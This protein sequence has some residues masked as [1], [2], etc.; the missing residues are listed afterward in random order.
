MYRASIA[1]RAQLGLL[2]HGSIA[3]Y[4]D[5]FHACAKVF[6]MFIADRLSRARGV[7]FW[8]WEDLDPET[9]DARC[10]SRHDTGVD[11]SDGVQCIVQ[12]KLRHRSLTWRECATFFAS[13]IAIRQDPAV[14]QWSEML[15]ARNACSTLSRDIAFLRATRKDMPVLLS[16]FRAYVAACAAQHVPAA[17]FP[18][19][20]LRDYQ[21]EAIE[22]CC[23]EAG[24]AYVVL[25][26]GTGKNLII[27]HATQR[28]LRDP[29]ARVLV[30]VPRIMLMEQ[31]KQ[32]F[33]EYG[34]VV[35]CV[36][37][38]RWQTRARVTVCVYDS[39]HK[40]RA[41]LYTRVFIDEAH[42]VLTPLVYTEHE[43]TDAFG[44]ADEPGAERLHGYR[45]VR[46]ALGLQTA[47]LFSAT[48]DIPANA[49]RCT[50]GLREMI[51]AGY[52]SDFTMHVHVVDPLAT[53]SDIAR[54]LIEH[55]DTMI[56]FA[57]TRA[58]C[59]AFCAT[60]N[61]LAPNGVIAMFIDCETTRHERRTILEAFRS[62]RILFLV[63][64]RV[65]TTGYDEP[66][67]KG[68]CF[69]HTPASKTHIV[70][71]IGRCLRVHPDKRMAVVVL[72]I[73]ARENGADRARDF[74]RVIASTDT[75]FA[76]A[77]HRGGAG[78]V[79]VTSAGVDG[80][81]EESAAA[82]MREDILEMRTVYGFWDAKLDAL[83]AYHA[84]HQRM[85][86]RSGPYKWL[87]MWVRTQRF[88]QDTM[89]AA[90][91]GRLESYEW[92][93]WGS[94]K[95]PNDEAWRRTHAELARHV[96]EHIEIPGTLAQWAITQRQQRHTMSADRRAR[97]E[98][99]DWW[100]WDMHDAAWRAQYDAY[101][102]H[103]DEHGEAVS[104]L[105]IYTQRRKRRTM[106]ADR[107]ALLESLPYWTWDGRPGRPAP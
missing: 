80:F 54:F 78:Y 49:P 50:R 70:Q 68:V 97:L 31:M 82:T 93:T 7:P 10:M 95:D 24:P 6:E 94:R 32:V 36:G 72:P 56:I 91:R 8:I 65:L 59:A 22:L 75:R 12:C 60:M 103:F 71:A 89:T 16:E 77:M 15:I 1:T 86:P 101:V 69:L 66:R 48:L 64:V 4:V 44:T 47:R 63:T 100:V 40:V 38:G 18:A 106:R 102:R 53:D 76:L 20:V 17:V 2:T 43:E 30:L 35:D 55:Y 39:A 23:A 26:T 29:N 88:H 58:V 92:W 11:V 84:E 107:V 9:K 34:I 33:D 74:M 90:R 37:D 62:G 45:S 67:T 85:P 3:A 25:P 41:E 27:V 14:I 104:S 57:P 87:G 61:A 28:T 83:V 46:R 51:E 52:I 13:A 96:A 5:D 99:H 73:V 79:D 19:V 42:C 81:A 98:S 105:W 21:L